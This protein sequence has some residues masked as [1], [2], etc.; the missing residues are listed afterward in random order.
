MKQKSDKFSSLL[1]TS[2][3]IKHK[4]CIALSEDGVIKGF[5][6]D[7]SLSTSPLL[8]AELPLGLVRI[9]NVRYFEVQIRA[10]PPIR[11]WNEDLTARH[12][13]FRGNG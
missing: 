1:R 5:R 2:V 4:V 12:L 7:E 11:D 10:P 8:E 6:R 9:P 13:V 3:T